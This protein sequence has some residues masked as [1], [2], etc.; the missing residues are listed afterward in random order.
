MAKLVSELPMDGR[1]VHRLLILARRKI[2]D[3]QRK[4]GTSGQKQPHLKA[5]LDADLLYWKDLVDR[6]SPYEQTQP[7][8]PE[9]V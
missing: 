4:W 8:E 1:D 5:R 2:R 9:D 3:T 7:N 6:L